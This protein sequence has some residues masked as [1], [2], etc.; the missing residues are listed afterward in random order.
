MRLH[1]KYARHAAY[2]AG[3]VT[4]AKVVS[5][6]YL[7]LRHRT[8]TRS[9]ML[10]G[11]EQ[12]GT[13]PTARIRAW[14]SLFVSLL[15]ITPPRDHDAAPVRREHLQRRAAPCTSDAGMAFPQSGEAEWPELGPDS[16]GDIHIHT[17]PEVY[18]PGVKTQAVQ[19][20][21]TGPRGGLDRS[22]GDP[23]GPRGAMP[24]P[25]PLPH[26]WSKA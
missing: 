20:F 10:P 21:E 2:A 17:E 25:R 7:H 4:C 14:A 16:W 8:A 19:S 6:S 22:V 26:Y 11:Y 3:A 12:R 5:Y 1:R 15:D 18:N 9:L 24:H 23:Q 13:S